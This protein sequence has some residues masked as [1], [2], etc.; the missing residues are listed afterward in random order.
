M[1]QRE[2]SDSG[3]GA[4]GARIVETASGKVQI[5]GDPAAP[6]AE[7]HMVSLEL[8]RIGAAVKITAY[9]DAPMETVIQLDNWQ[10]SW[11]SQWL[12]RA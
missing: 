5:D 8:E 1:T 10:A 2:G 7:H 11:L 12:G 6:R 4:G 3:R 9:A